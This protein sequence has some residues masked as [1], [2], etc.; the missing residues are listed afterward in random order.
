MIA[1]NNSRILRFIYR[2]ERLTAIYNWIC[3]QWFIL[4]ICLFC[5]A[6]VLCMINLVVMLITT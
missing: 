5:A 4:V 6:V 2:Y 1:H 3:E